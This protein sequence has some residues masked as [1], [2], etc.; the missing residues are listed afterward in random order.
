[1]LIYT[2]TMDKLVWIGWNFTCKLRH[3]WMQ[4][5]VPVLDVGTQIHHPKLATVS[6]I[7]QKYLQIACLFI[8][9]EYCYKWAKSLV[10]LSFHQRKFDQFE[11]LKVCWLYVTPIL[12][13]IFMVTFTNLS[14]WSPSN[15]AL[16]ISL[17]KRTHR[18]ALSHL[19]LRIIHYS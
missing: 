14:L 11:L 5:S 12:I 17:T 7:L 19:F 1:M 13:F 4:P 2:F 6:T 8:C 10:L 15:W 3:V 18:Q 9:E 16:K